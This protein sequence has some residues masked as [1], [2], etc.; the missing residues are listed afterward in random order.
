MAEKLQ[1]SLDFGEPEARS[2]QDMRVQP[3]VKPNTESN[4]LPPD[5]ER[6]IDEDDEQRTSRSGKDAASGP[7]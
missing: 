7:L 5:W 1:P 6:I 3:E 4:P 2:S